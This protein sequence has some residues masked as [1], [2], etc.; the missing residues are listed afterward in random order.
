[1]YWY[2]LPAEVQ[3]DLWQ[4]FVSALQPLYRAGK[5]GAVLLQ[6]PPWVLPSE[7]SRQHIL[8]ARRAVPEYRLAIEFRDV[9]WVSP[10]NI[11]RTM[12]FL[13]QNDLTFVCVD[14]PQTARAL[15]P[16]VRVT[17]PDLAVVRFHG[18]KVEAWK[19]RAASA[20]ERSRYLYHDNE[21]REWVPR[22]VEL[23]QTSAE[24]HVVFNN[25]YRDYAVRNARQF[26][27]LLRRA[28][29]PVKAAQISP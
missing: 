3:T 24:S 19:K 7:K 14:E 18:R 8:H 6:F 15:P 9:S 26:M 27:A 13:A 11:D 1:V 20:A 29:L 17:T 5:L 2:D 10:K 12:E 23:A 16:I 28:G 25:A 22:L 21:L 4:R